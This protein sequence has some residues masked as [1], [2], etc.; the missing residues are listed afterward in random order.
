MSPAEIKKAAKLVRAEG[1]D[2][3]PG[4]SIAKVLKNKASTLDVSDE[5][6]IMVDSL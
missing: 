4:K 1:A 6:K 2:S 5:I 3:V